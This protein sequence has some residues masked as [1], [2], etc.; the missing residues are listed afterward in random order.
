MSQPPLR[1]VEIVESLDVGGLERMALQLAIAHWKAGH[2][3]AIYTVFGPGALEGEARSAGVRVV[4]FHKRPGFSVGAVLRLARQLRADR[5]Q[6]VHTHNSSIHHYGAVAGKLA[7]AVVVNTRHGL[8]LHSSGRQEVYFKAVLPLTSA[9]VFVCQY[10]R[11]YFAQKGTAPEAK[12]EVILNGIPLEPFQQL[13]AAPGSMR[14]KI[15]FGTIG[16]LVKAKA[17]GDLLEAFALVARELPEAELDIWGYGPLQAELEDRIAALELGS[18]VHYR[19]PASNP[20]EALRTLDIFVLSSISE[21][22]PLVILEAMAAGLPI[23]STRAGGVAEVAP[24]GTAAWF[25]EPGNPASLAEAMRQA[26]VSDLAAA[27]CVAYE[28]A[29]RDYG[30]ETMQRHYES[31]FLRLLQR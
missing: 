2:S 21:G 16:R 11:R 26:A 8:A 27:G 28:I 6:I 19:G 23:V 15:R 30:V 31:L 7:G 13:R 22:L 24:E 29:S 1:I 20:A 9:V 14:P 4:S 18:R 5:A 12:S 17:H 3:S 25:A 10:G